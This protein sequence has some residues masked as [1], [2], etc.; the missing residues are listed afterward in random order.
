MDDDDLSLLASLTVTPGTFPTRLGEFLERV[1][2]RWRELDPEAREPFLHEA[3]NRLM[4]EFHDELQE[5]ARMKL[6]KGPRREHYA[7]S[8]GTFVD[9]FYMRMLRDPEYALG[10]RLEEGSPDVYRR[11]FLGGFYRSLTR[12]LIDRGR[13]ERVGRAGPR[14]GDSP[15]NVN[16]GPQRVFD[17]A[18]ARDAASPAPPAGAE[19]EAIEEREAI[20]LKLEAISPRQAEITR[21]KIHGDPTAPMTSP[22]FRS[23]P[24]EEIAATLGISVRLVQKEWSAAKQWLA[25][26]IRSRTPG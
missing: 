9:E 13:R 21:M 22:A 2:N 16:G 3:I 1:R 11:V 12:E 17:S 7:L 6:S 10:V 15:G 19:S 14:D 18:A 8:E 23:V 20:L 26:A 25:Q 24:E 4:S 5:L